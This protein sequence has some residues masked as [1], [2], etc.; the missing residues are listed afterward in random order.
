MARR[1]CLSRRRVDAK[2]YDR[3]MS[4][5][6]PREVLSRSATLLLLT[7]FLLRALVP[8]GWMPGAALGTPVVICTAAGAQTILLDSNGK[9]AK[10]EQRLGE[11]CLFAA[12]AA[13]AAARSDI[14]FAGPQRLAETPLPAARAIS[15]SPL[16][17][18]VAA[19]RAPPQFA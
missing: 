1:A 2:L 3:A 19:A 14:A 13:V 10:R 16:R 4:S 18:A 15:R 11:P 5:V 6:R 8:A 12:F 9:P 7:A 17:F